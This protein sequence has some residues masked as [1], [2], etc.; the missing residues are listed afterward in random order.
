MGRFKVP[1]LNRRRVLTAAGAAIAGVSTASHA[2]ANAGPVGRADTETDVIV[3]GSGAAG[4]VAALFAR[5]AGARVM[6]VE[7]S[8]HYGGTSSKSGGGYWIPNHFLLRAKGIA[9]P[10]PDFLKY[11]VRVAYPASYDPEDATLGAPEARYR[12]YETFYDRSGEMVEELHRTSALKSK[13]YVPL[14]DYYSHLPENKVPQGRL[15]CSITH[16]ADG[17]SGGDEMMW[18]LRRAVLAAGVDVRMETAAKELVQDDSGRVIGLELSMP[19]GETTTVAAEGGVVFA[20][21]GFAHNA[22]LL[23]RFHGKPVFGACALPASTGDFIP[24]ATKVGARLGNTASAWRGQVVLDEGLLYPAVPSD[25]WFVPF[26]SMF[27]VNRYGHRCV[28]EH[29]S[30]H[31][32][33]LAQYRWN[34]NRA[35]YP[36]LLNFMIYDQ[37]TAELQAGTMPIPPTPTGAEYVISGQTLDELAGNVGKHLDALKTRISGLACAPEFASNLKRS[38]DRFNAFARTGK[39]EDFQRGETDLERFVNSS[40]PPAGKWDNQKKNSAL[41]PLQ[42]TG[43]Y[44]CIILAPGLLDTNG[45]PEIDTEARI[46]GWNG[47]PIPGLYGAGNC[48]ASPAHDCYW[49]GGSTLALA[50]TFGMIAGRNAASG[51]GAK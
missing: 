29:R 13:E 16:S 18:Q 48:V 17:S 9:D 2:K 19:G 23:D 41:Y 47:Q 39:D 37:R 24:I 51:R 49:A 30:Y 27:F 34:P 36:D 25:V 38:F 40:P 3:V 7:K 44:Y 45:G 5:Q 26:D 43:P 12:L 20:S 28:N 10:K 1:E 31:E 42:E 46:L 4:S 50:M 14:P 8:S 15:L 33:S 35:E 6:L 11:L 21:G 22:E 32:R